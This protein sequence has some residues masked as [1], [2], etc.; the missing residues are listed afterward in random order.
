MCPRLPT[1][2]SD[3]QEPPRLPAHYLIGLHLAPGV[4]FSAFFFVLAGVFAQ[5]GL[6]A[7]L[8][9]LIAI[10]ACLMPLLIGIIFLSNRRSSDARSIIRAITYRER[11]TVGDYVLWPILLYVC[12]ALNSLLAVPLTAGLEIR[13]FSWFPT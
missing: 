2:E 5:H 12:W 6:T 13:C 9:E 4:V 1:S 8:A 10:P 11:G 7:C 3:H